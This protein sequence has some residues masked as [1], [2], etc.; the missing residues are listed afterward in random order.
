[1]ASFELYVF[2]VDIGLAYLRL[3]LIEVIVS[4]SKK[5]G[6]YA[7]LAIYQLSPFQH[8]DIGAFHA[9]ANGLLHEVVYN[10]FFGGGDKQ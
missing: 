9:L 2:E 1:M 6:G 10:L 7:A 5:N 3:R 4:S 8:R